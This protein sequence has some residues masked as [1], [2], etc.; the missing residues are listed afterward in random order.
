MR[1]FAFP[2]R[3]AS[4][5]IVTITSIG[6]EGRSQLKVDNLSIF[7]I[8]LFTAI[9]QVWKSVVNASSDAWILYPRYLC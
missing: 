6:I 9:V 4:Q 3:T 8:Y 2:I 7:N 5:S 1:R